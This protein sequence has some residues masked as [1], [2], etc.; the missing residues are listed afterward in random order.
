MIKNKIIIVSLIAMLL[1]CNIVYAANSKKEY[2]KKE[3]ENMTPGYSFSDIDKSRYK[4]ESDTSRF[5]STQIKEE[6]DD[7]KEEKETGFDQI[8]ATSGPDVVSISP[9]TGRKYDYWGL[10]SDGNWILIENGMPVIGWKFVD[11]AWYYMDENGIMK[12][13]WVNVNGHWYYLYSNGK[14]ASNTYINGYYLG[15]DGAMR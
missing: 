9:S 11:G 14:M 7:D 5:S 10:T 3:I 2:D 6:K 13:G 12:T 1:P 15:A 8:T 4:I